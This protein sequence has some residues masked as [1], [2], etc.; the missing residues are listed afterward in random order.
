MAIQPSYYSQSI[1]I[2]NEYL[3]AAGILI[4]KRKDDDGVYG[5]TALLIILCAVDAMGQPESPEKTSTKIGPILNKFEVEGLSA[6]NINQIEHWYRNGLSHVG[7]LAEY[8]YIE[9]GSDCDDIFVINDG[10]IEKI[11]LK[12]FLIKVNSYWGD[13]RSTFK[14]AHLRPKKD[15]GSPKESYQI[16]S[17]PEISGFLGDQL[18]TSKSTPSSGAVNITKV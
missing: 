15:V 3:E 4:G 11:R 9:L 6:E 1:A 2:I 14:A 7:A 12:P 10:Q 17:I 13:V 8:I 5:Y 16:T 18:T